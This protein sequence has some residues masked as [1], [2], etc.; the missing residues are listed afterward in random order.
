MR[1]AYVTM[2]FPRPSETFASNDVRVLEEYGAEVSVHGLG[3]PHAEFDRLRAE[4]R[5]DGVAVTHNSLRGSARGVVAATLN[6]R[7]LASVLRWLVVTSWRKPSQLFTAL[8]LVPRAFEVLAGLV[9][10]EPDVVHVYWGHYPSIVGYLVQ[11][12]LPHIATSLS[13]A[14]YDLTAEFPGTPQVARQAGFVRTLAE[15]NVPHVSRF[16]GVQKERIEVIYDGIDAAMIERTVAGVARV[17][18]R[19]ATASRLIKEKRVD[20]ALTIFARVHRNWPDSTLTIMGEG[21]ERERL[22]A[23]A[24]KLGVSRSV[25]FL[26]HVAHEQVMAEFAKAEAVLFTSAKAS[27]RLP[28]AVKEGMACGCVCVVSKTPGIF[29]LVRPGDTGFVYE[30]D[31]QPTAEAILEDIFA[32]RVDVDAIIASAKQDMRERFDLRSTVRR[33][34]DQWQGV[35]GA[36]DGQRRLRKAPAAAET[37]GSPEGTLTAASAQVRR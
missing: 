21:P 30:T 27:E 8:A 20:E 31:R 36:R 29:E 3:F 18:R 16:T 22:E 9:E 23:L 5:L 28:N 6:P 15:F 34:L 24:E 17:P 2:Q 4:R 37:V 1:I 26:G 10:D 14:A 33:Y 35:L 25:A 19:L 13:L 12:R 32:R 7:L 11:R